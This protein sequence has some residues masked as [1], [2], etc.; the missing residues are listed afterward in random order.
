M[1]I[2]ETGFDQL[3]AAAQELDPALQQVL[4][5]L[6]QVAPTQSEIEEAVFVEENLREAG[7]FEV[8]MPLVGEHLH[9]TSILEADLLAA[10]DSMATGWEDDPL[11]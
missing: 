8:V 9:V 11:L 7:A 3:V 5:H 10:V 1:M 6:M 2:T 4:I